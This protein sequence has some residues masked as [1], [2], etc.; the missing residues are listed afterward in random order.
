MLITKGGGTTD[1]CTLLNFLK[2]SS[3]QIMDL[4]PEVL[5]SFCLFVNLSSEPVC[6][7][8]KFGFFVD[9]LGGMGQRFG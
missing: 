3:R 1:T 9:G 5:V 6:I 2:V 8:G 7:T 4:R